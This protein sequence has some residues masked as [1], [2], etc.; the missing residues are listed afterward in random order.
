MP[1][2]RSTTRSAAFRRAVAALVLLTLT[3]LV[4]YQVC[5]IPV[6]VS[7]SLGNL[8]QVQAV[9]LSDVFVGQ[10]SN[11]AYIRPLLWAQIKLA[12][13]GAQGREPL[14]FKALHVGQLLLLALLVWRLMRVETGADLAAAVLAALVL[15]GL[16]TFDGLVREAFPINSFLT[17]AIAVLAVLNLSAGEPHWW[18]DAAAAVIFVLAMLTI[19]SGVLVVAALVA[20]RLAGMRGV[21]WAGVGVTAGVFAAYLVLRFGVLDTGSPALSERASGFGFRMLEPAELIARFGSNPLPFYAYNVAASLVS[22]LLAEPRAGVWYATQGVAAGQL[23]PSWLS[24]NVAASAVATGLVLWATFGALRRWRTGDTGAR[25]RLLLACGAVLVANAVV[26]F[27]YTKDVIMSTGGVCFALAVYAAAAGALEAHSR[28]AS[29]LARAAV[30]IALVLWGVR[31]VALPVRLEMQAARVRQEWQDVEG[32]LER[33]HIAV[34]TPEARA[35]VTRLRRSALRTRPKT[36]EWT[37]WR[38]ILDLN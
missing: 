7:D 31:A 3:G 6:Q 18:R 5:R 28:P 22:V 29:R 14:M 8:L 33:Q 17:I 9:P 26:S 11:G 20:A 32:W 16:H 21:S 24:I 13:D 37:G 38:S 30:A 27:G 2:T 36:I 25:D 35:L 4:A 15:F 10:F 12:Y 34:A 23:W 1:T 19:E